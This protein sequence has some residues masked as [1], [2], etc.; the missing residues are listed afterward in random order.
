M[1]N[2]VDLLKEIPIEEVAHH[3]QQS[4]A[5]LLFSNY[6]NAPCVISEAH[7]V[8]LPVIATKVGGISEMV[9]DSNGL[10]VASG[11]VFGM[12]AAMCK[13]IESYDRFDPQ[14]IH[15]ASAEKY[16]YDEVGAQYLAAFKEVLHR[17]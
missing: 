5:L 14:V 6:E 1:V 8:G 4:H 3:L 10:L 11:D 15:K 7:C 2:Q 12:Y 9:D 16:G 17:N 13:M